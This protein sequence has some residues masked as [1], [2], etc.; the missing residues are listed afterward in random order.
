MERESKAERCLCC[1]EFGLSPFPNAPAGNLDSA[2]D[3][4]NLLLDNLEQATLFIHGVRVG[5]WPRT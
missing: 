4:G 2:D 5:S 3:R 1:T